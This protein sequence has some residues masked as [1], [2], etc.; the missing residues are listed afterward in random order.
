V[1]LFMVVLIVKVM[2][3]KGTI[4]SGGIVSGHAAIAFFLVVTLIYRSSAD[5]LSI[6][7]GAVLAILVVQSRIE[8]KIHTMQEVVLGGLLGVCLPAAVYY[9]S[10]GGPTH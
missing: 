3:G 4:M 6:L 7:M 1:L 8:G 10:I 2:G 9:F 5:P